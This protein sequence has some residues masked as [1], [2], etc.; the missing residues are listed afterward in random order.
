MAQIVDTPDLHGKAVRIGKYKVQTACGAAA[1]VLRQRHGRGPEAY[2][3]TFATR[4]Q[5]PQDPAEQERFG[6]KVYSLFA[7]YDP[8]KIVKGA[9]KKHEQYEAD[10]KAK[11][12]K[13]RA[14][15]NGSK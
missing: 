15:K 13:A 8:T 2:G 11:L 14:E 5:A 7:I 1:N 9:D 6:D 3:W 10:R 12:E 4:V